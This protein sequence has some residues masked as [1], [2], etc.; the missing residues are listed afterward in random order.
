MPVVGLD[1]EEGEGHSG[2]VFYP[3]STASSGQIYNDHVSRIARLRGQTGAA[4]E[5]G[6]C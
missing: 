2:V 4:F 1:Y 3:V 6:A 5:D